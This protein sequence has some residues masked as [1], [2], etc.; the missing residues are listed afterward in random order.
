[1]AEAHELVTGGLFRYV[2][3]PLYSGN[4]VM[5]LGR[6]LLRLHPYALVLYIVFV[7]GQIHRAQIEECK[8]QQVFSEYQAYRTVTGMFLPTHGKGALTSGIVIKHC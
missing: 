8:L 4:F 7:T 2:R 6:L 5:F 3:H 1:M